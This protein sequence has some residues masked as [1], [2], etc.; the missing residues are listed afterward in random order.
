MPGVF[1]HY[2]RILILYKQKKSFGIIKDKK[3]SSNKIKR[4]QKNISLSYN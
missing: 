4:K 1:F 3:I 2:N